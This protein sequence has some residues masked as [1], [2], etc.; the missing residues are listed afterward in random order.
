MFL[1][2]RQ[3]ERCH[4]AQIAEFFGISKDHLAKAVRR[5]GQEGF[6]RT[7][8]GIGGGI[9]LA[10]RPKEISVGEVIERIEGNMHLLDCV[11]VENVCRIQPGCKLR[12]VL[13]EAERRQ[14]DYLRSITL[15]DIVTPGVDLVQLT[16]M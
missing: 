8:R 2:A 7:I 1:A 13:A 12:S 4:I 9:E 6:I 11:A 10:R 3:P 5:L 16:A 15:A 14:R